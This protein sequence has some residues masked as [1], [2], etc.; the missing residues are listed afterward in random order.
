[1][2]TIATSH[3]L[4]VAHV[5]LTSALKCEQNSETSL[6]NLSKLENPANSYHLKQVWYQ[7]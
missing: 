5:M 7:I 4:C 3:K 1:M 6:L 2:A